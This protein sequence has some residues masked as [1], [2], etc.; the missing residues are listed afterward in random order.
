MKRVSKLAI[1]LPIA[2]LLGL[3]SC[4]PPLSEMVYDYKV[5]IPIL[6]QPGVPYSTHLTK[7]DSGR[8]ILLNAAIGSTV[9]LTWASG[10]AFGPNGF[11]IITEDPFTAS[12]LNNSPY[13]ITWVQ[14]PISFGVLFTSSIVVTGTNNIFAN[15]RANLYLLV[16][17]DVNITFSYTNS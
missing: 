10:Q 4:T 15:I 5:G 13:T 1:L 2:I 9:N 3:V 17:E 11:G 8:L 16:A 7:S 6:L 14:H 12:S